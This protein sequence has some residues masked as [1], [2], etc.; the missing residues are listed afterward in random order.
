GRGTPLLPGTLYARI[1]QGV[2]APARARRAARGRDT[3]DRHRPGRTAGMGAGCSGE[4]HRGGTVRTPPPQAGQ[5]LR[6][7]NR[8]G[9]GG[10]GPTQ[11]TT[12]RGRERAYREPGTSRTEATLL[13]RGMAGSSRTWRELIARLESR[14]HVIAPAL[15]GHGETS[16]DFADYSLGAMASALRDLLVDRPIT[17]ST[18][19][20]QS[21]GGDVAKHV[22]HQD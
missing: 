17:R 19:I 16:P 3:R 7:L 5:D 10:T 13:M 20:G 14:F 18:D 6:G 22:D 8:E 2:G 12:T 4:D 15:P 21:M 1:V 11:T 9:P